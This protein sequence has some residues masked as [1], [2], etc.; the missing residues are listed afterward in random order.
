M[1][2]PT[3]A[4]DES[5]QGSAAGAA[6]GESRQSTTGAAPGE[7]RQSGTRREQAEHRLQAADLIFCCVY[8]LR[9]VPGPARPDENPS[10]FRAVLGLT[11]TH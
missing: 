5:N 6:P 3:V 10:C 11:S 9:A 7:S 2:L 8:L 4:A 1:I